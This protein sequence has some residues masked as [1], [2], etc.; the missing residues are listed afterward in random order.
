MIDKIVK[1]EDTKE[2]VDLS[3]MLEDVICDLKEYDYAKYKYYKMK[4][5]EMAYGCVLNEEMA[6]EIVENMKPYHEHWPLEQTTN[7]KN[8][9]GIKDK[10]RDIDFYVVMN[11][12]YNDFKD[13]F[14]EDLDKYV[15]YTKLFILDEDARDG[16]VYKYYTTIPKK[17]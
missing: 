9:Y 7:V 16:K 13:L 2:M 5:Y 8:E 6:T 12:A 4:L 1:E 11:S 3:Y 14:D 10:I 15:E 17:D